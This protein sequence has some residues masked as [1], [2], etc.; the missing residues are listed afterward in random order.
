MVQMELNYSMT[1]PR[2]TDLASS[3]TAVRRPS[4]TSALLI[5]AIAMSLYCGGS[6]AVNAGAQ[7]QRPQLEASQAGFYR[8]KIGEVEVTALSD[9][10]LGTPVEKV[11]LTHARPNEVQDLLAASYVKPTLNVS[12]N[13][14]LIH[15]GDRLILIDAGS[16]HLYGPTVNKL[17]ASLRA[18]G[19]APEQIT[20]V[21]LTHIH[22]DHSGGLMDGDR[23]AFP[24][25]II[26]VEQREL[27]YWLTAS[28][29]AKAPPS[30]SRLFQE[31]QT[32]IP[33]YLSAG[34]VKVF[35]AP[36]KL[37]PGI[38]ALPAP[39]HTPGHTFFSLESQGQKLVFWGDIVHVAE[40]QLVDPGVAI[41]FDSDQ[42]QAIAQ[43]R[44]AFADAARN[45]YLVA[46]AHMAFPGIGRLRAD[47]AGYR[48]IPLQ[49]INDS[50]PPTP[51]PLS[52]AHS[53]R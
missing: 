3:S 32:S 8:L 51:L 43:R 21:L 16:G 33:P 15:L 39:G 5:A 28:N 37:F 36:A 13:A 22:T 25:A 4:A 30:K 1:T 23:R 18:A 45:G 29:E 44:K 38:T 10:T 12:V 24:N 17:P 26:H 41:D 27:D 7:V 47:G 20:D 35:T 6:A 11:Q 31:A 19:V 40:V 34:E 50:L 46:P 53:S 48:W 9:G 42:S 2:A 49:Y 14:Y 52:P